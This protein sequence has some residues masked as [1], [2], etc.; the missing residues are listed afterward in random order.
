[1]SDTFQRRLGDGQVASRARDLSRAQAA[2]QDALEAAR[3]DDERSRALG[4]LGVV[5]DQ[6]LDRAGALRRLSEAL[7]LARASESAYLPSRLH[8]LAV[9]RMGRGEAGEAVPLLEEAWPL[10]AED[11][12][13]AATVEVLANAY[14]RL[15]DLRRAES[16]FQQ[17]SAL[18][19][20]CGRGDLVLRGQNGRGEALRRAG[21]AEEAKR[22]F[23]SVVQALSSVAEPTRSDQEQ[24]GVAL[25]NLGVLFLDE[26]AEAAATMLDQAVTCFVAAFGTAEHPHVARSKAFLGALAAQR[27]DRD[28]AEATWAEAL[29][30]VAADDPVATELIPGL[31][32]AVA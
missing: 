6:L 10:W 17:M 9:C 13:R 28:V 20:A 3:D 1:M 23:E 24:A 32:A 8:D 21:R 14:L 25:H 16:C 22:V 26:R 27:G 12:R 29:R 15:D 30:L 7:E 4:G 19:D 18:G 31:R 2:Y 5:L 11:I